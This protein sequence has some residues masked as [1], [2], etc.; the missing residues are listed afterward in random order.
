M[1]AAFVVVAAIL[2]RSISAEHGFA[3]S[4]PGVETVRA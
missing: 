2:G 4:K 1:K 3:Q